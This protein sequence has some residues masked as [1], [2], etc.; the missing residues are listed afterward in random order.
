MFLSNLFYI[1]VILAYKQQVLC[2]NLDKS[3]EHKLFENQLDYLSL[4]DSHN[5]SKEGGAKSLFFFC[6]V[7]GKIT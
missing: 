2:Y 4:K 7:I 6:T 5:S 3:N 1:R